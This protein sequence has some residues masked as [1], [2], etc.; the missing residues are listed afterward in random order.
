METKNIWEKY[1][2][3]EIEQINVLAGEYIDF[4]NKG[5]TE[6]ECTDNVINIIEKSRMK[7]R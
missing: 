4:L 6:R 1:T 3:D 2:K 7:M 5:K